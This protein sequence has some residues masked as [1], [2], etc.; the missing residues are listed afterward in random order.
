M[1]CV[2]VYVCSAGIQTTH[3]NTHNYMANDIDYID[4]RMNKL[5]ST[6]KKARPQIHTT[7]STSTSTKTAEGGE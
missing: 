1:V 4:D 6:G 5:K 7:T 2:C 3:T